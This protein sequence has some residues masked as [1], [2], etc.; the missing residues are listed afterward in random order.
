MLQ[1]VGADLK[2]G[3]KVDKNQNTQVDGITMFKE[4]SSLFHSFLCGGAHTN[5]THSCTHFNA[6]AHTSCT[7]THCQWSVNIHI[8]A[9]MCTHA[10]TQPS[11]QLR[12][13]RGK[14]CVLFFSRC[15]SVQFSSRLPAPAR[16][17]FLHPRPLPAR[18]TSTVSDCHGAAA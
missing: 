4:K 12:L 13:V 9:C 8:C 17:P 14:K 6:S 18:P 5:T 2:E 7:F 11:T 3:P 10:H 1:I 16:S 15:P